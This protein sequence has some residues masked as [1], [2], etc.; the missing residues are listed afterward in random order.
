MSG[1]IFLRNEAAASKRLPLCNENE[2]DY[3]HK[4][5]NTTRVK[6][7]HRKVREKRAKYCFLQYLFVLVH[8]IVLVMMMKFKKFFLD[9]SRVTHTIFLIRHFFLIFS[10]IDSL[11]PSR[12]TSESERTKIHKNCLWFHH[13]Q[14]KEGEEKVH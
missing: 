11:P 13:Q 4:K 14:Q 8:H 7:S 2:P 9:K 3:Y 5:N 6:K 12:A 10:S 1:N